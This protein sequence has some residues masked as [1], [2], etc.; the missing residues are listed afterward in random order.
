MYAQMYFF[1]IKCNSELKTYILFVRNRFYKSDDL[2]LDKTWTSLHM[3]GFHLVDLI[4]T[5]LKS[6]MTC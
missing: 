2:S 5:E 4:I 6:H 3:G 1:G